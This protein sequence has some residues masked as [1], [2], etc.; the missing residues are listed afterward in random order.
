MNISILMA[1]IFLTGIIL[2]ALED[3]IKINKAAVSVAMCIILW[4]LLLTHAE[5]I[6]LGTVVKC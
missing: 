5:A 3:M 4:I 2:I 1:G 6:Y